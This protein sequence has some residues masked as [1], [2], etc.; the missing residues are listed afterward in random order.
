M[1]DEQEKGHKAPSV[2]EKRYDQ[3]YRDGYR[4]GWRDS[5]QKEPREPVIEKDKP[6]QD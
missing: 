3:G 5:T 1:P 4:D 6:K 2:E